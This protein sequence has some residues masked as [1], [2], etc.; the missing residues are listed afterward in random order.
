MAIT[1]NLIVVIQNEP[2]DGDIVYVEKDE[3]HFKDRVREV[4]DTEWDDGD[5]E[6]GQKYY[7]EDN[8]CTLIGYEV[9]FPYP[10]ENVCLDCFQ[11]DDSGYQIHEVGESMVINFVEK[12][13]CQNG[14]PE[15]E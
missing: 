4:I 7:D 5:I 1:N 13:N 14:H 9:Q 6:V 2:R 3:Q 8:F 11:S 15:E 12:A 10:I